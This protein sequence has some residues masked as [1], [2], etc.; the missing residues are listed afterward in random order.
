MPRWTNFQVFYNAHTTKWEV[1]A[2]SPAL[3]GKS[4]S[5]ALTATF[6][7]LSAACTWLQGAES[8]AH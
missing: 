8:W 7:T 4:T 2:T 1:I 3:D 5:Q 6:S